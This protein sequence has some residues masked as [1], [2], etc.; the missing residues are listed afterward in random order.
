LGREV[1]GKLREYFAAGTELVWYVDPETRS[2]RIFTLLTSMTLIDENGTL[3]GAQVLP[4]LR[5]PLREIF[6]LADAAGPPP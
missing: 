4:G 1:A 2:A 3:D 5:I 6:V